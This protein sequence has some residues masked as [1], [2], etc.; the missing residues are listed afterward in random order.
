MRVLRL[1]LVLTSL[2]ASLAGALSQPLAAT[3]STTPHAKTRVILLE[4]PPFVMKTDQG[5][6]GFAIDLWEESARNIGLDYEY[7][8]AHSLAEMLGE[9]SK[10][11][12]DVAVTE[13]TISGERMEQMDFTQPWFDAGLQIMMHKPPTNDLAHVVGQL[14]ENG[15]ILSYLLIGAGGLIVAFILTLIDR[16]YDPDFPKEWLK[17]LAESIYHVAAVLTKGSTN[18]KEL[19]GSVGRII[20]ALWLLVGVGVVAFITSSVTSVMTVNSMEGSMWRLEKH[21]IQ[22]LP[23]LKDK[24]VGALAESVASMYVAQAGLRG[25]NFDTMQNM[26]AALAENRIDAV[27]ADEPSLTYYLHKNPNL[28]I[29]PVGKIIKHEKYGFAVKSGSP[30]RIKLSKQIMEFWET[31]HIQ[32][33]RKKY[34]GE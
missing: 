14:Y 3:K 4:S 21:R 29:A 28:P 31:G 24:T 16:R 19:F 18:H 17:G 22:D 27:V 10:G 26:I 33:L 30:L 34:F 11:K 25:R 6:S 8:E 12:A 32:Q 1:I 5:Y 20:S 23:D 9:I 2:F 13:L 7:H 15:F